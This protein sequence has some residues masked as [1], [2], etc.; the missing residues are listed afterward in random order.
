LEKLKKI[1]EILKPSFVFQTG[2]IG[3]FSDPSSMD[4][5]AKRHFIKKP[6]EGEIFEFINKKKK[7]PCPIYF[8]RGNHEDFELLEKIE[9]LEIPE[10]F[11]LRTGIHLI[12]ELKVV[13]IGGIFYQGNNPLK[14]ILPKYTQEKEMEFLFESNMD[15]DI[16][17]T[18]DAPQGMGF[19]EGIGG[20]PYVSLA[21]E[22]LRPK[23][24]FH[25]HYE[26]PPE[27]YRIGNTEVY[28]MTLMQRR[29]NEKGLFAIGEALLGL[30]RVDEGKFE[31]NYVLKRDLEL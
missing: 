30:L 31:F 11:Y 16:L 28:P 5:A 10:F 18:H 1:V 26:N 29:A 14:A 9:E 17:L 4:N 2:D 15:V 24:L 13:S 12:G 21:I 20:S 25:G 3:F 27:P 6:E 7:F 19:R 23:F 22:Y 8:V